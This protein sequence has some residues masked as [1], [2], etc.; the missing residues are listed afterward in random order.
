MSEARCACGAVGR[1]LPPDFGYGPR[2][3]QHPEMLWCGG[4]VGAGRVVVE[5]ARTGVTTC[6]AC[7]HRSSVFM[8]AQ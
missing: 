7:Q 2:D 4:R 6:P 5:D 3:V 8:L 1:I